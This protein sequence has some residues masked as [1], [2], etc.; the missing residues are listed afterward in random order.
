MSGEFKKSWE[1]YLE[2]VVPKDAGVIQKS[3]TEIAFYAGAIEFRDIANKAAE[4]G[5]EGGLDPYKQLVA[6]IDEFIRRKAMEMDTA[7]GAH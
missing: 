5:V 6:E 1:S 4:K 3:E 7:G 2:M